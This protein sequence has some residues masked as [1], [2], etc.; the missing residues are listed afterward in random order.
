MNFANMGMNSTMKLLL[1]SDIFVITG[2]GF[3]QPI[4]AIFINGGV[5]GGTVFAAGL[6]SALFLLTKSLVQ[7]PFGKYIDGRKRKVRWLIAGTLLMASVPLIYITAQDV[8]HVYLAEV[9][10]GIGSGLAYP[11]WL[12]LWS[13]NLEKGRESFQWSVYSTSTGIGTAATGAAGAGLVSLVGFSATFLLAGMMCLLGCFAL[14]VLECR[15]TGWPEGRLSSHGIK[16]PLWTAQAKKGSA[17]AGAGVS[18]RRSGFLAS[19]M[20]LLGL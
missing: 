8:A 2:F 18:W 17:I 19:A 15:S 20:A 10:Y 4:L 5:P 11:T 13:A 9:I 1:L 3:I 12:G 16:W 14:L 6:A 7:L